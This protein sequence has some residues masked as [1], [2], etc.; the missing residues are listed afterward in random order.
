[1]IIMEYVDG[2]ELG[3]IGPSLEFGQRARVLHEVCDAIARAHALGLQHRDLK[4]SNIMVDAALAPKILDFGLSAGDP[5]R[6]HLVGT[7]AY[8]APE[9]LDPA[10]AIDA[11]TDVYALGVIL[12]ELL[13][14]MVPYTGA[15]DDET[16]GAIAEGRPRLPVEIDPRVPEPL[17]A[18]ALKAMEH[19]PSQ[20]YPSAREMALDLARYLDGRPVLARPTLYGS[21]LGAR[22]R[23]H[24]EQIREWLR[25]KLIYPHEAEQLASAYRQ[26]EAR[27]DDW[28]VESRML[29][30][31]QIALYL[32]AF[33]LVAG[34][35]FYFAAH[36]IYEAVSGVGRPFA[37]LALPFIG[38][39]LAAHHLYRREHKAVAV[40]FYLAGVGL[41]PLF[42]LILFHETGI[43][44]VPPDSPGQLFPEGSVSNRQLQATI[45]AGTV[46]CGWL[47]LRTRTAALST[48]FA[49]LLLLLGLA[50]L[51]DAGLRGWLDDG[52]F[53]RLAI[54]LAPMVGVYGL[55]GALQERSGRPWL[56]R[57]LHLGAA[58][59]FV[60]VLEL[61]AL[62]GHELG[63]LGV[64]LQGYQSA[65]VNNPRL[66]DTLTAMTING[67]LIYAAASTIVRHGSELM[68]AGAWL[69]FTI[70]PF[71]MLQPIGYLSKT[72]EY[73][74]GFDWLYA[75]CAVAIALLSHRRQRKAFYYAGLIN[76]GVALYLIAEHREWFDRPAWAIALIAVGL[77]GLALG[78]G[79][80]EREKRR[81]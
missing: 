42:L 33:L 49:V 62:D 80:H 67:V 32:G 70:S 27:E 2:F 61:L 65:D 20:R 30:Y 29:S 47:A 13:C 31:S 69:L 68:K 12:Y 73:A 46:W 50:V 28:I 35:L 78:F 36:R 9:Q 41:L 8:L 19:D 34:S 59:L 66:I 74:L 77:A 17:Q 81:T 54:H 55:G 56:A 64:T 26:L 40:A 25:L 76:T 58:A 4:P 7:L 24:L 39:N 5:G 1:V 52:R 10:R 18:I 63:Y 38:L 48:A 60:L 51:A 44:V 15:T 21:V 75:G 23:P 14:G 71:A 22:V 79:L 57:P 53:D 16:V 3:R 37:A 6:G 72:G 45:L 11:R 43:W